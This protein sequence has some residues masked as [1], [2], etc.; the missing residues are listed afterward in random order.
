MGSDQIRLPGDD[1][2]AVVI[3]GAAQTRVQIQGVTVFEVFLEM[4]SRK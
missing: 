3:P 1:P 2:L 4:G